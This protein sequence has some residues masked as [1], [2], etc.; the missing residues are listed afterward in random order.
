[1]RRNDAQLVTNI[2]NYRRILPHLMKRRCDSLVFQTVEFDMTKTLQ[3]VRSYNKAHKGEHQ[4]RVFEVFIAAVMRTIALRPEVNRF[5]QRYQY[6]QRNELSFTFVTKE[7]YTDEAPEHS[8][9]IVVDPSMHLLDIS[10]L[11][12]Q[13]IEDARHPKEGANA[14][15][16]S[17]NFIF[18]YPVWF[19]RMFI[20]IAGWLDKMGIAPK[21]LREADGL[22]TSVFIASLGSIGM[23]G[24]SPH[25]HLYE[26][27]TT[28]MFITIGTLKRA[29]SM[30][31]TA[32][33][34]KDMMEVGFTVDERVTDGFYFMSTIRMFQEFLNDPQRLMEQPKMPQPTPKPLTMRKRLVSLFRKKRVA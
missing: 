26:W 19:I 30:E 12:D 31:G 28:S 2:P 29:T 23:A 32:P 6:W 11:I 24:G 10:K 16:D 20:N 8:T 22:H 5:V 27:G 7:D 3:F 33:V 14:T 9:P 18:K 1:M 17:I 13:V 4:I 34:R 15:D 21:A 25:H